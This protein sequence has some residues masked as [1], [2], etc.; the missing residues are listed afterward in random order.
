ML[1]SS[2][3]VVTCIYVPPI[4]DLHYYLTLMD[5]INNLTPD[6]NHLIAGDLN[7]PD[8][9]WN[10]MS[11]PSICSKMFCDAIFNRN[12]CQLI[13][14]PTH[15]KGNTLDL[16]LSDTPECISDINISDQTYS[17]FMSILFSAHCNYSASPSKHSLRS[18]FNWNKADWTGLT[19]FLLDVDFSFCFT[20]DADITASWSLL[21]DTLIDA[22]H[23]FVPL[24]KTK[25]KQYPPWYTSHIIHSL[26][27]VRSLRR[28]IKTKQYPSSLLLDKLKILES[29]L[30]L[31]M[32]EAREVYQF[33]R[34]LIPPECYSGISAT[35]YQP[36]S[37]HC[38]S[39]WCL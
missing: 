24:R 39:Q 38:S 28:L 34:S 35:W 36:G 30:P 1:I 6:Y 19:D 17:Y 11:A 20:N 25:S 15:I 10:S 16:V 31:E 9:D 33:Q 23:K 37:G 2:A 26:N 18:D 32:A 21:R 3:L 13:S 8:I 29:N 12:L 27:K 22:C 14:K 5:F 4:S 7:M